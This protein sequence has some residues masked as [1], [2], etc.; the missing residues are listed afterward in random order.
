MTQLKV[1]RVAAD[2]PVAHDGGRPGAWRGT[3][4]YRLHGS[5]RMYYST[6]SAECLAALA[7]ALLLSVA[8]AN[9]WCIFDNTALGAATGNALSI[10]ERIAACSTQGG[11]IPAG[12]LS[13]S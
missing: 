2:P 4:Y 12:N 13:P 7:S 6:Y 8:T 1:A 10:T 5:P 9:T 11:T 3:I